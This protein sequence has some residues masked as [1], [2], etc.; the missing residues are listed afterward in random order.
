MI[1]RIQSIYIFVASV[2]TICLFFVPSFHFSVGQGSYDIT[3]CHISPAFSL[4]PSTVMLP[5]ALV[6]FFAFLLCLISI[7]LFRNRTLQMKVVRINA[8]LQI[9]ILFTMVAYVFF[10]FDKSGQTNIHIDFS[11]ALIFPIVNVILLAFARKRIKADDDL[12]KSAD[13]LR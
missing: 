3:A 4:V 12:V 7:F 5:L 10:M 1:Q 9:V 2:L 8:F 6:T 13:R 11:M